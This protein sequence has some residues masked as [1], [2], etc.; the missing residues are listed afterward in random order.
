M[1]GTQ[2]TLCIGEGQGNARLEGICLFEGMGN[3]NNN[4]NLFY[5]KTNE[6]M[7]ALLFP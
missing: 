6:C 4:Q 1:I 5:L 7:L 3:E 2:G